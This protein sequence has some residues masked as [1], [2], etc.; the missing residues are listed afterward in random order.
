MQIME[1]YE[2]QIALPE[3]GTEGQTRL[4][5]SR[6]LVV[7]I[8]GLGCPASLYLTAA[9]VGTLGLVDD[10]IISLSNLQRQILYTEAE[11]GQPK[12]LFAARRLRELNKE[13]HVEIHP[14]RLD[15]RNAA[16]LIKKYDVVLDGCDNFRTRYILSDV[17]AKIGIPYV[18]GAINRFEGQVSVF[19]YG[20]SPR[21][22]RDLYP[23]EEELCNL[24]PDKAVV[25][26]TAGM[27]ACIQ[28]TEVL[29][30]VSGFGNVLSGRLWTMDLKT[31]ESNIIKF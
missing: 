7:G 21:T 22:Y 26:V 16:D 6:V 10:D 8:G 27:T 3:I 11:V 19:N 2:R 18:Y 14:Y 17:C 29:K 13:V 23:H 15:K 4:I 31:M 5:K 25:G 12:V 9:G 1:R 28:A 20:P 30:I 24:S